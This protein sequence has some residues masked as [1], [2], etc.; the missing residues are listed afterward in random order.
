MDWW[1][2]FDAV[3]RDWVRADAESL[4]VWNRAVPS[5]D[6]AALQRMAQ[7]GQVAA[8]ADLRT[9]VWEALLY[10][11]G[12]IE[13]FKTVVERRLRSWRESVR[14]PSIG[15]V[16]LGCGT[17]TVAFAFDE[18][19]AGKAALHYVG[20][21]HHIESLS[22]CEAMVADG[23]EE[24][25][26][27]LFL[28]DSL[29]DAVGHA[30]ASWPRL[31]R[32]FVTSNYL[33]CQMAV[34]DAVV[35]GIADQTSRLVRARGAT[36]VAIADAALSWSKAPALVDALTRNTPS[37]Q[38]YPTDVYTYEMKFPDLDGRTYRQT[39]FEEVEGRYLIL[40]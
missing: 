40:T 14:T 37:L 12:H 33:L 27:E 31:D 4:D 38:E 32:M 28:T 35:A 21:D 24:T 2:S 11:R 7:R 15:I 1:S 22:L 16:D 6:Y 3:I 10:Q 8:D 34:T 13:A 30:I 23:I 26:G 36:R 17:G 19:F 20:L 29:A 18:M 25:G 5:R 39:R 9:A